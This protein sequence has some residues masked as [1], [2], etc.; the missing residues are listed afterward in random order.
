MPHEETFNQDRLQ[1][2]VPDHICAACRRPFEKG[3]RIHMVFILLDPQAINPNS[4]TERGLE[5][6]TDYEFVHTR[7]EDPFLDGKLVSL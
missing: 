6:G 2:R 7:C 5:L 3:N 4:L 1:K